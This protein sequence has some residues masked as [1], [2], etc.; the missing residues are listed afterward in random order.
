MPSLSLAIRA[1]A[2]SMALAAVVHGQGTGIASYYSHG[3]NGQRAASGE[4]YDQEKFTAAHRTLPF[5]T[6]VRVRRLDTAESIVVRINDRGPFVESRIIDLS[7]AAARTLGM[8]AP[9]LAPVSLQIIDMEPPPEAGTGGAVPPPSPPLPIIMKTEV[10]YFAVLA[11]TFRSA[12]KASRF[13]DSLDAKCGAAQ[14]VASHEASHDVWRVMVGR[15]ATQPE[16]EWLA[17]ELKRSD[18]AFATVVVVRMDAP[19]TSEQ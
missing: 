6:L 13:R 7:L 19:A 10:P 8:T 17:G 1:A 18:T 2:V 15:A 11:A 12:D 3:F 16:A 14:V 9:G 4:I 5:G